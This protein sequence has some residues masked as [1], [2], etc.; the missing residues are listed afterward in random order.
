MYKIW[1]YD[2]ITDISWVWIDIIDIDDVLIVVVV[3]YYIEN[4]R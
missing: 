2:G 1:S 4:I 3:F